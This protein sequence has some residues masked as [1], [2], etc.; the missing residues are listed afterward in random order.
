[1]NL[2]RRLI[3]A[4]NS[5]RRQQ[6]LKDAGFEF[7][8][9]SKDVDESFDE[10]IEAKGVAKYLAEKKALAYRPD[11]S[12]EILITADTVV[13]LGQRIMGK[14]QDKA[15]ATE[16]L[17]SLSGQWHEVITG[18]CI[19]DADK[20]LSFDDTTRVKFKS[21]S[22]LEI[23]Y[24]IDNYSPYDKAGAYGIQEWIG[25]IGIE[26]IEGSYFNVMGLP[27]HKLYEAL[28]KF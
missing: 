27:I 28:N 20:S 22:D 21:L 4:S 5:P 16:M 18:V 3:L 9:R 8:I 12:K 1:M 6:I 10:T 24:Y 11:I 19:S 17:T 25:Y 15:E 23:T 2:S 14:P 7:D 26:T 13:K